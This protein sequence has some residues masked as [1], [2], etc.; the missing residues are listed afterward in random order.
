MKTK[1][2]LLMLL[3]MIIAA[4][5]PEEVNQF[6]NDELTPVSSYENKLPDFMIGVFGMKKNQPFTEAG[7]IIIKQ[8]SIIINTVNHKQAFQI[9][10]NFNF[11]DPDCR[12][13]IAVNGIEY[14][15]TTS[16]YGQKTWFKYRH[17]NDAFYTP[18]GTYYKDYIEPETPEEPIYN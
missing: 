4:C 9:T 16:S 1:S 8:D 6:R 3:T 18:V 15:F 11:Y 17:I 13:V 10:E 12:W 7:T 14:I 5:E 2:I